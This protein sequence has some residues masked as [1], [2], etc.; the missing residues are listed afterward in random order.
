MKRIEVKFEN[1]DLEQLDRQASH[2][3]VSRSELIRR[4]VLGDSNG[5]GK[6]FSPRE[7]QELVSSAHRRCDLPR[8]QVE[9]LVTYVFCQ[10]LES[11]PL[12][13]TQSS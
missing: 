11:D 3:N 12:E 7:F 5:G 2:Q 4:R 13:A 1:A 6:K 10:V 8:S 9:R